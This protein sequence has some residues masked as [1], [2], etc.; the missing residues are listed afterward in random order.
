M[1]GRNAWAPK[2]VVSLAAFGALVV[3]GSFWAASSMA[4]EQ[5]HRPDDF[6]ARVTYR[7]AQI[8]DCSSA[9]R[10]L[11]DS[12]AVVV[13]RFLAMEPGRV[14]GDPDADNAAYYLA[15]AF[16]IAEV[17]YRNSIRPGELA[18]GDTIILETFTFEP[19]EV[20][21]LA[22]SF[23]MERSLLFLRNKGVSAERVGLAGPVI[24]TESA[25]YRVMCVE[26][27]IRDLPSGPAA[28]V[29]DGDR[30]AELAQGTFD[31]VV[32]A[33]R[34]LAAAHASRSD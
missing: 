15:G 29:P 14:I 12:D 6:W 18:L 8:E 23:P 28:V 34:E 5:V 1:G 10:M 27:I 13:G 2:R 32:A 25:Y 20:E 21:Q 31:G 26:G 19:S 17:I 30:L 24:A 16:E 9:D 7:G 3:M 11:A 33:T 4:R 22:R